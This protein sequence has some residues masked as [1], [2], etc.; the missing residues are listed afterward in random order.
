MLWSRRIACGA[1]APA[2]I[3]SLSVKVKCAVVTVLA[4]FWQQQ[5]HSSF[6]FRAQLSAA[7]TAAA[8]TP[9]AWL[10]EWQA[11]RVRFGARRRLASVA[12]PTTRDLYIE[13]GRPKP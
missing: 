11:S 6:S 9:L 5:L 8:D 1:P 4:D 3:V 13:A 7:A 10:R 12:S 2:A